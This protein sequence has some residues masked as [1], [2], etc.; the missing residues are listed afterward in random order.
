VRITES[1]LRKI[2]IETLISEYDMGDDP[3]GYGDDPPKSYEKWKAKNPEEVAAGIKT[4]GYF[5][6]AWPAMFALD[7]AQLLSRDPVNTDHLKDFIAF[8]LAGAGIGKFFRHVAGPVAK[9]ISS[10]MTSKGV[11]GSANIVEGALSKSKKLDEDSAKGF[12]KWLENHDLVKPLPGLQPRKL[13]HGN[14][15]SY[16]NKRLAHDPELFFHAPVGKASGNYGKGQHFASGADQTI[17]FANG[18]KLSV[19]YAV[20]YARKFNAEPV[21]LVV[22]ATKLSTL[23]RNPFA[24]WQYWRSKSIPTEAMKVIP[25]KFTSGKIPEIGSQSSYWKQLTPE[26]RQLIDSVS[27]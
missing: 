24:Y 10:F 7:L 4:L 21:L 15:S 26:T 22:D 20:N 27:F 18:P 14:T 11:K 16:V 25:L 23:R 2:I 17:F 3:F 8:S 1:Q 19:D 5:T 13:F 9:Y 12:M 6:P